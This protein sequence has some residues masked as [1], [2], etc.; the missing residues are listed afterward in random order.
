[1]PVSEVG[2]KLYIALSILKKLNPM[3]KY[4]LSQFIS[5]FEE[6]LKNG[7]K[8]SDDQISNIRKTLIKIVYDNISVGLLKVHRLLLGVIIIKEIM[9]EVMP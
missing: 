5:M 9:E 6:S 4:N 8:G 2:A 7:G 1:M 3:Y